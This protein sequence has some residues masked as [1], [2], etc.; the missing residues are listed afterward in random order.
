MSGALHALVSA[1]H[2]RGHREVAERLTLR[3]IKLFYEIDCAR[4]AAGPAATL[5]G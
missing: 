5:T 4:R 1:G 2:G 3:Q